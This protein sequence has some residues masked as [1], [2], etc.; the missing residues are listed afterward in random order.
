MP[1]GIIAQNHKSEGSD[2]AVREEALQL[3]LHGVTGL[4]AYMHACIDPSAAH[5]PA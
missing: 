1:R 2:L 4:H 3:L 5:A